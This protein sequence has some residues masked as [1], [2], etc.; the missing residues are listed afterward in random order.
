M[1][2]FWHLITRVIGFNFKATPP[3]VIVDQLLEPR[4]LP[5]TVPEWEEWTERIIAGALV[6]ADSQSLKFA[7]A[8]LILH[9]GPTESHKPDSFFIHSLRKVAVNQVAD[10][11][12]TKIRDEVK[13]RLAVQ[14]SLQPATMEQ[15]VQQ[16]Q[17]K[18]E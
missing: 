2:W 17:A 18:G 16:T 7:L 13:A 15:A 12:R 6:P 8:N 11:M 14:E 10:A 5:M 1:K 4:P 3:E 9:L